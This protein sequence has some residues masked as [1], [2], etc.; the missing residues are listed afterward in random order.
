MKFAISEMTALKY[1]LPLVVEGNKRGIHSTLILFRSNKYN[2][3]FLKEH[4][5]QLTLFSK[6][7]N[8]TLRESGQDDKIKD[9]VFFIEGVLRDKPICKSKSISLCY[10]TDFR[11]GYEKYINEVDYVVFSSKHLSNYYNKHNEKNLYLGSPKF[12]CHLNNDDIINKYYL[13]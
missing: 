13:D 7:Y 2:C 3:P 9:V 6:I 10:S 11:M 4:L 5:E 12:D 1:F 8:F